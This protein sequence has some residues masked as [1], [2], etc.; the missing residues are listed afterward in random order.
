ME[1]I[2]NQDKASTNAEKSLSPIKAGGFVF[3][4]PDFKVAA[5]DVAF[6]VC[7]FWLEQV[8]Q[9]RACVRVLFE[10]FFVRAQLFHLQPLPRTL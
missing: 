7:W 5:A 4:A 3:V 2:T 9:S 10:G 8:A 1:N 6:D